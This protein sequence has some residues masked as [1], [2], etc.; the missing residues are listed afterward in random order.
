[1][2]PRDESLEEFK[3][4]CFK[5]SLTD[6]ALY[7]YDSSCADYENDYL[8]LRAHFL[9]EFSPPSFQ[10]E[11]CEKIINLEQSRDETLDEYYTYFDTVV[12]SCP[13]H[14][15]TDLFLLQRFLGGMMPLEWNRLSIA[16]GASVMKLTMTQIWDL[17]DDLAESSKRGAACTE[18][19]KDE[20]SRMAK[21]ELLKSGLVLITNL[22]KEVPAILDETTEVPDFTAKPAETCPDLTAELTEKITAGPV[23]TEELLE[24]DL[25]LVVE[26]P[27]L[28][29]SVCMRITAP[30]DEV[31]NDE[32]QGELEAKHEPEEPK[33]EH[34]LTTSPENSLVQGRPI[35]SA[36][37]KRVYKGA[38]LRSLGRILNFQNC[39]GADHS[40]M[41]KRPRHGPKEWKPGRR[42]KR[43]RLDGPAAMVKESSPSL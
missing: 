6:F 23:L 7:W 40:N 16:A 28:V 1:M 17:I 39:K 18:P 15:L 13:Q 8:V 25:A 35:I 4:K 3:L 42:K 27:Q 24:K 20:D 14:G 37:K 41:K 32:V 12:S 9:E 29:P 5:F 36:T 19:A 22:P 30:E 38:C 21:E 43:A 33:M 10:L 26:V 2:K 31:I 34:S 11:V